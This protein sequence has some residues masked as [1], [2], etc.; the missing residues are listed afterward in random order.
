MQY[1]V[2]YNDFDTLYC[3][4][5]CRKCYNHEEYIRNIERYRKYR[6][7]HKE[8]IEAYR[9]IDYQKNKQYYLD[10]HKQWVE[11]NRERERK[12]NNS[13][14]KRR[15]KEDDLYYLKVTLRSHIN[16]CLVRRNNYGT[17]IKGTLHTEDIL[18]C[19]F[20]EFKIYI[21]KKFQSGM[22]WQNHGEWHLDHIIPLASAKTKDEVIKL[23][24]YINYQPLWAKD[25]L[26]KGAKI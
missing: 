8:K 17:I 18:G 23:C 7:I 25:N 16:E 2:C 5:K 24:H 14:K 1:I 12:N 19:S 13:Y 22:T 15:M 3:K 26:K 21:E 20:E 6:L 11:N 9:K 4:Q 10:K